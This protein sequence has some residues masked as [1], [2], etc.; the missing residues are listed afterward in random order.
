MAIIKYTLDNGTT[1]SY[2]SDGGQFYD[3]RDDTYIGIG[4]GGGAELT[5]A[6]LIARMKT[7][8]SPNNVYIDDSIL[9]TTSSFQDTIKTHTNATWEAMINNWCTRKGIS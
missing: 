9:P 8:V 6:Q 4:S 2:I 3:P 7:F 1:P 5:K